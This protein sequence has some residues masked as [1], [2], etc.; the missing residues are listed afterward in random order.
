MSW[1]GYIVSVGEGLYG[2]RVEV[3]EVDHGIE[4][5]YGRYRIMGWQ[6]DAQS[7]RRRRGK[8]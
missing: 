6:P 2:Q 3:R 4:I 1:R 5:Y 7:K 8:G